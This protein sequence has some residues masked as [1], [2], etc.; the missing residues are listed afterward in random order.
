[1][2]LFIKRIKVKQEKIIDS[3]RCIREYME[4]KC[5]EIKIDDGPIINDFCDE[6][7]KCIKKASILEA[8]Y[9]IKYFSIFLYIRTYKFFY[10]L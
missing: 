5:N 2:E 8:F 9:Y 10:F 1:M 6:K 7:R 4:N 3:D